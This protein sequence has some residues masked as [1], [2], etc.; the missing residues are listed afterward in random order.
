MGTKDRQPGDWEDLN[1]GLKMHIDIE[2]F[3][4]NRHTNTQ[5][6]T[7]VCPRVYTHTHAREERQRRW[8]EN[9]KYILSAKS[10]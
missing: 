2:A 3:S 8:V 1:T 5:V 9:T 4:A 7:Y 10:H 6:H